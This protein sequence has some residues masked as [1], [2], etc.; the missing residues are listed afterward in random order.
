M[1]AMAADVTTSVTAVGRILVARNRPARVRVFVAFS[2]AA[3]VVV[4]VVVIARNCRYEGVVD[5][6]HGR[7]RAA[8][9]G[10]T[11]ASSFRPWTFSASSNF[12]W[13]FWIQL[14]WLFRIQL[15]WLFRIQLF[16]LS[17]TRFFLSIPLRLYL[18][19]RTRV[20]QW[21]T[22]ARVLHF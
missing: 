12:L 8:I 19:S 16:R 9:G 3:S 21:G 4:V 13:L 18:S 20:G 22:E 1:S 15:F 2:V 7:R 14:F 17:L 11:S 5:H 10:R 6:N